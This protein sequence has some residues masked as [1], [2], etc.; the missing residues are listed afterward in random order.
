MPRIRRIQSSFNAGVLDPRLASRV[1]I[2]AYYAG[3]EKL[4][5][6]I[7]IPQ[8]GFS[9]RPGTQYLAETAKIITRV[10]GQ[11]ITAPNGGTTANANDDDLTTSLDTTT[12]L[13]TTNPYVIVHYDLGSAKTIEFADAISVQYGTGTPTGSLT[14]VY[15][16]YSTD[17]ITFTS[18][19]GDEIILTG[20]RQPAVSAR[21]WRLARLSS[22]DLGSN[23]IF[24]QEFNL[25]EETTI[26]D[27]RLIPFSF[28]T[29][30]NYMLVATDQNLAIYKDDNLLVNAK[31][32][33]TT[34]QLNA[35]NWT[36]SADTLI[37]TH[38][39]VPPQRIVRDT[40]AE[41]L[42][43]VDDVPITN[44][45]QY[46]F[47]DS[48]SPAE[49]DEIQK[50]TLEPTWVGGGTDTFALTLDGEVTASIYHTNLTAT[51]ATNIQLALRAL[52]NTSATG[53]TVAY[54]GAANEYNVT[55]A[56]DDGGKDWDLMGIDV[57][58]GTGSLSVSVTTEG[59]DG[60]EDV[61]SEERGYPLTVAFFNGRMV[62][63]GSRSRP[64][65]L[66]LSV[67]NDFY[68][69]DVGTGLPDE[70]IVGALDTDQVNEIRNI[71]PGRKLEIYTSGGE[72]IVP[73]APATPE[74]FAVIRQTKYGSAAVRPT[75]IDGS[76]LYIQRNGQGLRE[77]IFSFAEDSHVSNSISQLSTHLINTPVDCDSVI[78]TE[79]TE[80][81]YVYIV[82]TA[83]D[84]VVLNTL[85]EQE[86]NAWSGPWATTSGLFKRVGVVGFDTYFIVRRTINGADVNYLEKLDNTIYTD[87]ALVIASHTGS[88]VVN[89]D[90]LEGETVKVKL[91]GAVQSDAVVSG[92]S[93]TLDRAA[94]AE[95]V[96]VGL[97]F[98]PLIKTMPV[99][100]SFG[101]GPTLNREKRIVRCTIN[102]YQS[103]GILVNG[104]RIPDR[105]LDVDAFD[106]VPSPSD[107]VTEIYL[108]G[109]S[110]TAQVEITQTDPV[111]MTILALDLEVSA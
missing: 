17:N 24:L 1:D 67:T 55:F 64:Q 13:S 38:K 84:V 54:G 73:T 34:T 94:D 70:A 22:G 91:G 51:T 7:C 110:K 86:I 48:L 69:F 60:S 20:R 23:T 29:E 5:N 10:T 101:D 3:A 72:F 77:L 37:I 26:S 89:L 100:D 9:R 6:A 87:S 30:Q 95:A 11:T 96:E 65:G 18:V 109:W 82:N 108:H 32:P 111:P 4:D 15:I 49:I 88:T 46:D 56:G 68:N 36:Q 44:Y 98:N 45:P 2:K 28:N 75:S 35:I 25:W 104:E 47:S 57:V 85:R 21:Y 81:N 63:G 76:T 52:S 8:G 31:I 92:G 66:W 12:G 78:G 74:N 27:T 102:R 83:G 62:F 58:V 14:D 90:Y 93:I 106:A 107:D 59:A 79:T 50:V 61:W 53:I 33:H 97:G 105:Q 99:N 40:S 71:V 19:F 103:L 16:Q 41:G 39:D 42:W 43:T 80:T